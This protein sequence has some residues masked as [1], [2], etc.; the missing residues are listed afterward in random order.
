ML[1]LVRTNAYGESKTYVIK[2]DSTTKTP[3]KAHY[4]F[5]VP[6]S[7]ASGTYICRYCS[8]HINSP[9]DLT[10]KPYQI[11]VKYV[12][13]I[14]NPKED[15]INKYPSLTI[16][17]CTSDGT[18]S[19]TEI[20]KK[21]GQGETG[22]GYVSI[23]SNEGLIFDFFTGQWYWKRWTGSHEKRAFTGTVQLT[24][25]LDEA[26]PDTPA[27]PAIKS[28][29]GN[30]V[31]LDGK[32]YTNNDAV[33]FEWNQV[34]DNKT[35]FDG[36]EI[37]TDVAGAYALNINGTDTN[38]ITDTQFT[39]SDYSE[40]TYQIKL[41][42]RDYEENTSS[43]SD[44]IIVVIDRSTAQ[45]TFPVNPIRIRKKQSGDQITYDV[46]F[47][48][49]T[50]TEDT[51]VKYQ[52]AL[53]RSSAIPDEAEIVDVSANQY[54]FSDLDYSANTF[55]AYVRA[56]DGLGNVSEW[57]RTTN[58]I[59]YAP[60][61][62]FTE[63][64]QTIVLNTPPLDIEYSLTDP[65]TVE[66]I[67]TGAD[68][69]TQQYTSEGSNTELNNFTFIPSEPQTY[70]LSA[71]PTDA[72]GNIGLTKI[73][74]IRVNTPPKITLPVFCIKPETSLKFTATVVDP[75]GD[76]VDY[77]WDPG[78]GG[79]VLS[80]AEPTYSY[81]KE[82]TYT[83]TLTVTDNDG[84]ASTD[85][86][87]VTVGDTT[88]SGTLQEDETWSGI[89][90]IYGDIAVLSGITLTIAADTQIIVDG[91]P[92]NG[93]FH[94]LNIQGSLTIED[95]GVS[96]TSVTGKAGGWRGI[97]VS[98]T[99]TLSGVTI[100]HAERGVAVVDGAQVTID[101]GIFATNKVGLHV[102]NAQPTVSNSIFRNNLWYGIKEDAGG[103]PVVTGCQFGGNDIDY[104]DQTATLITIDKLNQFD[105]N[106]GNS[107][108]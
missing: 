21:F 67:L 52:V 18:I 79:A 15:G 35:E 93:Y 43:Y 16:S 65:A 55:Y 20:T 100:N 22:T 63:S 86:T 96:F 34:A 76:A 28:G 41:K 58:F 30:I 10:V 13:R 72:V 1:I 46:N 94:T 95:G 107:A 83:V 38:W 75:D 51:G 102:Y 8:R 3:R 49:K 78:D 47:Y 108:L 5:Y 64:N 50:V 37:G 14:S 6:T 77:Q 11:W 84:G 36:Y 31:E 62:D 92:D 105:G 42:A 88:T 12:Y 66:F 71:I 89:H 87:V 98:G 2:S 56:I 39:L 99:A 68:G 61:L 60:D 91:T 97:K 27:V 40:G 85:S 70:R 32:I 29:S 59:L 53:S 19:G 81:S 90:R 80:G 54:T 44:P 57:A 7:S 33:I 69:S 26:A 104:Y 9:S 24:V 101:Q 73:Q 103:R 48:W 106:S 23:N 74:E 4:Y 45:P 25:Q 17:N 82:G